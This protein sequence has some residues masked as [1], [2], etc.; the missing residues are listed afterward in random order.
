MLPVGLIAV[1]LCAEAF[2]QSEGGLIE[3]AVKPVDV[4]IN[5]HVRPGD[6]AGLLARVRSRHPKPRTVICQW[7]LSDIDG[8]EPHLSRR[9]TLS[10]NAEHA[11]WLYAP[12]PV[13]T[14][15]STRWRI[16]VVDEVDGEPGDLLAFTIQRPRAPIEIV[17]Q[18]RRVIGITGRWAMSLTELYESEVFRNEATV[19]IRGIQL[20]TLPD[21]WFGLST[22]STLIWTPQGDE[23]NSAE[24]RPG[25]QQAILEWVRRG[26]HL[27]I[28]M[29]TDQDPW[30][31][32]FLA[33]AMPPVTV[34]AIDNAE[35]IPSWIGTVTP[36]GY[37]STFRTFEPLPQAMPGEVSVLFSDADTGL[38]MVVAR[39]YGFG[40]VTLI[41]IDLTDPLLRRG[42]PEAEYRFERGLWGGVFGWNSPAY[43]PPEIK[44]MQEKENLSGPYDR[45]TVDLGEIAGFGLSMQRATGAALL[46]AIF[47][48]AVY[49]VA[50]GP[51]AH[52]ALQRRK[53]L[54]HSWL[55][56][57]LVV[58]LFSLISWGG[59][60]VIKPHRADLRHVTFL[61]VDERSGLARAR[62]WMTVYKPSHGAVTLHLEPDRK[63][64]APGTLASVGV[65]ATD[66]ERGFIDTQEYLMSAASPRRAAFPIRA[67]TRRIALD[68]LGGN[69]HEHYESWVMPSASMSWNG[70]TLNATLVHGLP[71]TLKEV[72]AVYCPGGSAPATVRK[73]LKE[74]P[75]RDPWV[76]NKGHEDHWNEIV[77]KPPGR[78]ME[79]EKARSRRWRGFLGDFT[80]ERHEP[81]DQ[82][83]LWRTV[84]LLSFYDALPVPDVWS[85]GDGVIMGQGYHA[86]Q[87]TQGRGLDL[88]H[89]L[90]I[91][92]LIVIGLLEDSP[93]PVPMTIDGDPA[94]GKGLTVVRWISR[95]D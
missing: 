58:V 53:L 65:D 43:A 37:K 75:P 24:I 94:R 34:G 77:R 3:V 60:L 80:R 20:A 5:G 64:G 69:D 63:G 47:V 18:D 74:W 71:G 87:R 48:F 26:G 59:A 12:L 44:Q 81:K 93:L 28:V 13:T 67:T 46:L 92:C 1:V 32:S 50:A 55:V 88:T 42:Y 22:L 78:D 95:L 45:S 61:D 6:W 21:R 86:Y 73:K 54:A 17:G 29:P 49:W 84:S 16:N 85:S 33:E 9:V 79:H 89:L 11:I 31:S 39:G 66:R 25:T 51:G 36:P 8:D 14:A 15:P 38:P 7:V 40:R 91:K 57:F 56:F 76:W 35:I 52:L 27:V 10:P 68:Y 83:K 62:S 90:R 23:P 70:R 72:V 2:G 82:R 4:G 19:Y 41:G 30:S